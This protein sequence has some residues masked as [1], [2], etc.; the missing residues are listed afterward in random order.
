M[1]ENFSEDDGKMQGSGRNM[2]D[3]E[4]MT[5]A[6][7]TEEK[8]MAYT[9][10]SKKR[11][12]AFMVN[13]K[14]LKKKNVIF[15]DALVNMGFNKMKEEYWI[16]EEGKWFHWVYRYERAV[17]DE[18]GVT[19]LNLG[20]PVQLDEDNDQLILGHGWKL[21]QVKGVN[22]SKLLVNTLDG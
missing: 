12:H 15:I 19:L 13:E 8:K 16:N 4:E 14:H 20:V 6:E 17:K 10:Q 3:E 1:M 18:A 7:K 21:I 11:F 22:K 2:D 9:Y 5:E